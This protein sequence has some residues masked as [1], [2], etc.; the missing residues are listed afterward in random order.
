MK[1]NFIVLTCTFFLLTGILSGCQEQKATSLVNTLTFDTED[2][3]SLRLDYDA[4]DLQ[5]LESD[6]NKVIVKE[7]MNENKKSYYAR[8]YKQNDEL[9][10][11]EGRRPRRSSFKSYIELYIPKDYTGSLSLH[12]TRGTIKSEIALNL[13]GEFSVDTT[14]GRMIISNTKAAKIGAASTN[15]SLSFDNIAADEISLKTTNAATSLKEV[16][17]VIDYQSKGGKL[18]A[19]KLQGSGSFNASGEGSIDL[20]FTAV[21]HDIF[22]Y[23]K[24][25]TLT[26]TLPKELAFKFSATTKEGSIDTTFSDQLIMTENTFAGAVGT[27]PAITIELKTRNGAIKAVR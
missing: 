13:S 23:S 27:S 8:T 26:V 24:N 19:V 10:I 16:T 17:G 7:Y 21:T 12:S 2:F 14:S 9:V 4:D 25:G 18:T 11:T 6:S 15:G 3:E 20:S 1:C 22:A 5:L